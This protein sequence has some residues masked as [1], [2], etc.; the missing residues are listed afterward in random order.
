MIVRLIIFFVIFS[1]FNAFGQ[2][3]SL[4]NVMILKKGNQPE[5]KD[6]MAEFSPTGFYLYKN[7][8]YDL[9][10]RDKTKR[11]LRLIDIK[12]NTLIFIGISR[13]K[14]TDLTQVAK[15]TF[16][17]N[18]KS[19]DKLL[20]L[21][22]WG[23]ETSKKIKCDDYYFIFHKSLI[24][25][26]YESKLDYVFSDSKSELVPRLS[27]YGITYHYEYG[28]KLYYHSGIKVQTPKYSDEQKIKALNGVLT[29]CEDTNQGQF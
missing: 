17:I 13:K 8:F 12:L 10:F 9:K 7:C 16:L 28:G 3:D 23:S 24:E 19:I 26:R 22:D 15:D 18:Y 11:T 5:M 2:S 14:D 6:N 29:V 25:N 21:K 27:S 20:L 4:W 1:Q